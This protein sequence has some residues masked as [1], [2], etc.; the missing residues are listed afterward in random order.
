MVWIVERYRQMF[1]E[2]IQIEMDDICT[3]IGRAMVNKDISEFRI[4]SI[5]LYKL[6]LK[7]FDFAW[8]DDNLIDAVWYLWT[9]WF[10]R[11]PDEINLWIDQELHDSLSYFGDLDLPIH[12]RVIKDTPLL[13]R[14]LRKTLQNM[15]DTLENN[16]IQEK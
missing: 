4:E 14:E 12:H 2:N 9:W 16:N 8:D 6:Y 5:R 13:I 7:M 1:P 10:F 11:H 3:K 15:I